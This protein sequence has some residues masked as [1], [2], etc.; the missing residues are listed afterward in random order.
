MCARRCDHEE[1][2]D[3]NCWRCRVRGR[4]CRGGNL[5]GRDMPASRLARGGRVRRAFACSGD[6]RRDG[7]AGSA[8]QVARGEDDSSRRRKLHGVRHAQRTQAPHSEGMPDCEGLPA[9]RDWLGGCLSAPRRRP[10]REGRVPAEAQGAKGGRGGC[11]QRR[12]RTLHA[13]GDGLVHR[14]GSPRHSVRNGCGSG[15]R[16]AGEVNRTGVRRSRAAR[17]RVPGLVCVAYA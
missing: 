4:L 9:E 16:Q 7:E 14:G 13:E 17:R 5:Q 15:I 2:V 8:P 11:G 3:V 1:N 6:C 12:M 10:P